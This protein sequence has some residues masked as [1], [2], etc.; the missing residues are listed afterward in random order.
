MKKLILSFALALILASIKLAE[1]ALRFGFGKAVAERSGTIINTSGIVNGTIILIL[2]VNSSDASSVFPYGVPTPDHPTD[3]PGIDF[4]CTVRA[5][6]LA[7]ASGRV[8]SVVASPIAEGSDQ[9]SIGI[10]HGI[11]YAPFYT[12]SLQNI[13]VTVGKQVIQGQKIAE[14]KQSKFNSFHWGLRQRDPFKELCPYE[15]VSASN[16][17]I[18]EQLNAKANFFNKSQYP[19]VCNECNPPGGCK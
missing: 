8:S 10:D 15:Y 2:P 19:L 14:V 13:Q 5:P 11:N 3:H 17:T 12:G 9:K 18:L 7:S 4:F 6:V 1:S 16:K